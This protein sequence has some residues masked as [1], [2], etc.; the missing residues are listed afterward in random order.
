MPND[1][2]V[3]IGEDDEMGELR[4]TQ[5]A[6]SDPSNKP[7]VDRVRHCS[8]NPR[9]TQQEDGR[10]GVVFLLTHEVRLMPT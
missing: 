7:S 5:T 9:W 8:D 6:F 1:R 3:T 10:N 4:V 2:M